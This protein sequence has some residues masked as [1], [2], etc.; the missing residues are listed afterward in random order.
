VALYFFFLLND[1]QLNS[2]FLGNKY[3]LGWWVFWNTPTEPLWAI[4]KN[5][6]LNLTLLNEGHG[7]DLQSKACSGQG[8]AEGKTL[9]QAK[10]ESKNREARLRFCLRQNQSPAHEMASHGPQ[11]RG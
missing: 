7:H 10:P 4:N 2:P 9:F 6:P 8:F 1:L 3:R 5:V 11:Q